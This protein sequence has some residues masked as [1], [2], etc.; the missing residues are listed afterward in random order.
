M[1]GTV[2]A[3]R[4]RG[5]VNIKGDI[6][7]TL[8]FLGLTRKNYCAFITDRPELRGMIF[9]GK[10][11]ITWGE[12]DEETAAKLIKARGKI[13]GDK[14]VT[15]AYIKDNSKFSG[16]NALASAIVKGEAR[17][18]DVVGLKSVFRLNPPRKGFERKG[19]K[20]PFVSGGALGYRKEKINALI[21]RMI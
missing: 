17:M 1:S 4:V 7:E 6:E 16:I 14:P 8:R 9:K 3:I 21:V 5:R 2:A 11:Y 10:D 12:V 19:I 20:K 15:D 18:K 13:V